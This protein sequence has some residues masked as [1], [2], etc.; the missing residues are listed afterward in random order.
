M[1]PL[2]TAEA[3]SFLAQ[4]H[5]GVLV[6]LKSSDG[7]PQLSNVAYALLDRRIR[8][9]VTDGRAKTANVRRDPRVSLHVTSDDFWTYVVAEGDAQL[10]PLA[11]EAGDETCRRLLRLN[12][13]ATGH[14]HSDPDEFFEAMVADRRL[15]LSFEIGNLYPTA[16]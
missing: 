10:S 8:V 14:P 16:R 7:R 11:A 9:S 3:E 12:E 2:S 5:W 1:P 13:A 15:E 6:T 4:R